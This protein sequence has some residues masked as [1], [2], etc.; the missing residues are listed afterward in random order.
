MNGRSAGLWVWVCLLLLPSMAEAQLHVEP[1]RPGPG[2]TVVVTLPDR[3]DADR[4]V[5]VVTRFPGSRVETTSEVVGQL[6]GQGVRWDVV[7]AEPGLI[8]L[9]AGAD[10]T[11]IMVGYATSPPGGWLILLLALVSLGGLTVWGMFGALPAEDSA[12][13]PASDPT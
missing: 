10:S 8:R 6:D 5:L 11:N 2:E 9:Q 12:D 7:I 3:V 4:Q 13:T 1:S